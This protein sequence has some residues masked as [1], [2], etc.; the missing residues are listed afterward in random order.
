MRILVTL[1]CLLLAL[2]FSASADWV[3]A[4]GSYTFPP[5][6]PE[7]EACQAAEDR[8]R[9]EAVRQI[10]GE[11][12]SSEDVM[13]CSEQGDEAEC[14]HN[15]MVWT[16]VSGD[17]RAIRGRK[18]E[19]VPEVEGYRKCLVSLEADVRAAEGQP[20]PSFTIGVGLNNSVFR[21][22]EPLVV[23]LKPSQPMAVQIFQWL[24]YE[25]GDAQI[26]RIFPNQFDDVKHIE[27]PITVPTTA[28][29]KRYDLKVGFP[30]GMLPG[31]KMVDEYLMVVATR[32]PRDLRDNYSLDEF[33]RLLSELPR[34]DSRIVRRSYNI[35]RGSE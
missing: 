5:V 32:K 2:P 17:I 7:A 30:I 14:A 35:V 16:A 8:A 20:D 26:S 34:Q 19:T 25:K 33:R 31:R 23:T 22:G 6:M 1:V 12:L 24:P 10:T 4:E 3:H 18:I 11:T 28:G 29:A 9:S 15:S 13:R 27:K 21:D